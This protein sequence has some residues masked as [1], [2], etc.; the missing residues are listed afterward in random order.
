[1]LKAIIVFY[2][3]LAGIL[4]ATVDF[5]SSGGVPGSSAG[6]DVAVNNSRTMNLTLASLAPGDTLIIGNKTFMMMGGIVGSSL[7]DVNIQ[8]DGTLKFSDDIKAWPLETWGKD[9]KIP[10]TAIVFE[11]TTGLTI[12]STGKG[13]IDGSGAKWWG[14]PGVGYLIRG[15]DRP[16]LLSVFDANDFVMEHILLLNSARFHFTSKNLDNATIRYCDVSARRTSED[17]HGSVDMSAFNTDGFDLGG[18]NIHVH[19]SSVWNQDDTFCIKAYGGVTT[20]NVVIENVRASGVGLSIGSIGAQKVRNITFRNA[21]MHH[22]NK[23]IY[24]KYNSKS[25]SGG[26]ITDVLYENILIDT[27]ES[28]PIW[29]GPAQQDIKEDGKCKHT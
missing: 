21:V 16:P 28:W 11:N 9:P 17:G 8:I 22:T 26:S 23:G 27:P 12:T 1:M 29:I 5:E 19:D 20:E 3:A 4:A 10:R 13:T 6:T 18:K 7:V 15:K 2:S 25:A 24:L 14:I